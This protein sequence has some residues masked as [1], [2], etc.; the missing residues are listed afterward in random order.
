MFVFMKNEMKGMKERNETMKRIYIIR[1]SITYGKHQIINR[2]FYESPTYKECWIENHEVLEKLTNGDY[3]ISRNGDVV[4]IKKKDVFTKYDDAEKR[5]K[6][7]QKKV[8]AWNKKEEMLIEKA[9]EEKNKELDK[10]LD[11]QLGH[12]RQ[13]V[14]NSI[15][16]LNKELNKEREE[17]KKSSFFSVIM[18][19]VIVVVVVVVGVVL[20]KGV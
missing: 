7:V 9:R 16:E 6:V 19:V 18:M 3:V 15:K 10:E 5:L 17:E 20:V 13:E 1:E 14:E 8:S 4:K 12:F 11:K 2:F